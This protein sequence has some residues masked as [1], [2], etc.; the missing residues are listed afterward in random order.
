MALSARPAVRFTRQSDY[1]ACITAAAWANRT[2]KES[3][4]MASR[5]SVAAAAEFRES[6]APKE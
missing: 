3:G 1:A 5:D 4:E 2:G 6:A